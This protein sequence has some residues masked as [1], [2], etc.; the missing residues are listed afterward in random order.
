MSEIIPVNVPQRRGDPVVVDTD[1]G[2]RPGTTQESLAALKPAFDKSGTVT[3]GNASQISD[4]GAA[5]VVVS[6]A[7]ARALGITP[8]GE[9]VG[10]GQV[11]GPNASLML[12]PA[13]AARQGT[14]QSRSRAQ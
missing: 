10:Y 2:V 4:G 14:R 6:P 12:Q 5:V 3:A 9:V 8:L 7:R 1:E 13:N 11:S